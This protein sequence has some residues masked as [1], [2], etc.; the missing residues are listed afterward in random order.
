VRQRPHARVDERA[1]LR[2]LRLVVV[3]VVPFELADQFQQTLLLPAGNEFLQGLGHGGLLGAF[4][5]HFQRAFEQVEVD[6]E[7]GCHV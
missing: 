3:A 7:I 2:P 4:A 6:R 1:H 5:A